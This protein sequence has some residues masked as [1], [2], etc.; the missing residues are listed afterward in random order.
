MPDAPRL[1]ARAIRA[2]MLLILLGLGVAALV[3]NL[4]SSSSATK[5][6]GPLK[7]QPVPALFPDSRLG[8]VDTLVAPEQ[9]RARRDIVRYL[10]Q[11]P[12][13]N[14]AVFAQFALNEVG[15]PP[16]GAAQQ[17][18]L[19]VLHRI[20]A[21]RTAAGIAAATWLEAHGKHDIWKL[22][23]KQYAQQA[24][25]PAGRRA[26]ALLTA[27]YLLAN[28]IAKTGKTRFARPSPYI[29]DPTLHALNQQ[30]F[31]KKFS[32][33]AKH[34]VI[35]FALA[36]LLAQ[37]EPHRDGEYRWMRDEI[38]YSRMYA[39]GHYPSDIAAG[40]YLGTLIAGYE[41]RV[42]LPAAG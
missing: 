8:M 5:A 3:L 32:Y 14:D 10:Q 20:D 21:G 17:A 31:A 29:T 36:P 6:S 23:L 38:V 12:G 15:P 25:K 28:T 18:E 13:R 11:F 24:T 39:G 30:R 41:R 37:L 19:Q 2:L 34:A 26:K 1:D 4:P 27:S 9:A 40:A 42:P 35:A 33:P 7:G 22:Y 16:S